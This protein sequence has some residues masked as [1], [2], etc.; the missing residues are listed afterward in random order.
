[1]I[2]WNENEQTI[3]PARFH[4]RISWSSLMTEPCLILRWSMNNGQK[5][6]VYF[7]CYGNQTKRVITR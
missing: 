4:G 1:M 5:K 2:G 7:F 3:G 6:D